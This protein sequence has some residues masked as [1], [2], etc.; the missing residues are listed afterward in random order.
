MCSMQT[1]LTVQGFY[2][3]VRADGGEGICTQ[4]QQNPRLP[5]FP[6]KFF[7]VNETLTSFLQSKVKYLTCVYQGKIK[8]HGASFLLGQGLWTQT[9]LTH[10]L[11][12]FCV[13]QRYCAHEYMPT[14]A[15]IGV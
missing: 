13:S 5:P 10:A 11:S 15:R 2:P 6:C 14:D 8:M 3:T 4:C 1:W 12:S 7:L 9:R